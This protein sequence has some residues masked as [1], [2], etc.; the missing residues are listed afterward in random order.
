MSPD[1]NY[2]CVSGVDNDFYCLSS[3][4][5]RQLWRN[6]EGSQ[7]LSRPSVFE[8]E[9]R[10]V[11]YAIQADFGR[12]HSYDLYNGRRY[13]DY[14]CAD[15]TN[16]LC[17]DAVE[18]DF[19]I[20]PG[21]NTLYYGDI[22]GRINSLGVA[23]FETESPTMAPT[24]TPTISPSANP[25]FTA[26]PTQM[27]Q[28][29]QEADLIII[30]DIA[31]N[32]EEEILLGGGG[33]DGDDSGT[34]VASAGGN[35]GDGS[36]TVVASATADQQSTTGGDNKTTIYI[37]AAIAALC[38]IVIPIVL[39]SMIRKKRKKLSSSKEMVVEIVD[40]CSSDD[41]EAQ[42]EEFF[43]S[44][45]TN[46]A[47]DPNN[48]DGIEIEIVN[49][50]TPPKGNSTKQK[51]NG[52]LP[53]TPA[54]VN[55][56][57]NSM[58]D[59]FEISS[60]MGV[61]GNPYS[62]DATD[63][64]VE[65]VN[66]RQAFDHASLKNTD[67]VNDAN[68][69]SDDD[70]PPPP[71]LG[72]KTPASPSE[73]LTWDSLV[74]AGT[75]PSSKEADGT[76]QILLKKPSEK[77]GI[78]E[79]APSISSSQK[80]SS[81][82]VSAGSQNEIPVDES[83]AKKGK[84]KKMKWRKKNK[85]S[86]EPEK[87]SAENDKVETPVVVN[88]V[89]E[90]PAPTNEESNEDSAPEEE[91]DVTED[92]LAEDDDKEIEEPITETQ[93]S[94]VR[95]ETPVSPSAY[96]MVSDADESQ[97]PAQSIHSASVRSVQSITQNL[98]GSPHHSSTKSAGSDDDSLYTSH[99][100]YTGLFGG[101]TPEKKSKTP[102]LSPLASYV[103]N[104]DVRRREKEE[105]VNERKSYLSQP[106]LS[107]SNVGFDEEHPDDE[108]AAAPGSQYL[109]EETMNRRHGTSARAKRFLAKNSAE[110]ES[111]G[112]TIAQMYDQLAAIGQQ[113]REEKKP[114]F[115]RR[116][117]R[118]ERENP[119]PPPPPAAQQQGGSTWDSFLNELAEAEKEFFSP[120]ESKSKSF[121]DNSK[122]EEVAE[123]PRI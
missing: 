53:D 67:D 91:Q 85:K 110:N 122:T 43:H 107:K 120:S 115:R 96:S 58:E 98:F 74:K 44:I 92:N 101:G 103:Y 14:S 59:I 118:I 40:D 60:A 42:A 88:Q 51:R 35:D 18:A 30:E 11:V 80:E 75:S 48:G 119:T 47:Y 99:T 79:T 9:R 15:T 87:E 22:Y 7:F 2:L 117:K 83:P 77:L 71:P 93:S 90:P 109:A 81:A 3:N 94:T 54:T 37:G 112:T 8:G 68:Y 38:A 17:Q 55:D 70:I 27:P 4:N 39:F 41:L 78:K 19:A 66:L 104:Q 33:N 108:I 111:G 45:E 23:N 62:F 114:A 97:S 89:E 76:S 5:G 32:V 73:D 24:S 21:G 49:N 50:A 113:R 52:G 20:A 121:L 72:E 10:T 102:E 56:S 63:K 1:G 61:L 12:I 106:S 84:L 86:L 25:T 57:L 16:N 6:E 64:S 65:A 26:V 123:L 95:P 82:S 69:L 13:W 29:A 100:G 31:D 116:N 46:N 34:V 105:I 28:E 36:G